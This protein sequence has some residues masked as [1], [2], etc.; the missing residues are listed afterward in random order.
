MIRN[1]LAFYCT[2]GV[3]GMG[4]NYEWHRFHK[5]GK[6]SNVHLILGWARTLLRAGSEK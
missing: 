4:I 3:R 6:G 1:G 5:M 2:K